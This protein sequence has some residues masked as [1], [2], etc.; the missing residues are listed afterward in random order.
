MNET[1]G[2]G[3]FAAHPEPAQARKSRLAVLL[4][5]LGTPDGTS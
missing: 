2:P 5:N 3:R 1:P 4:I